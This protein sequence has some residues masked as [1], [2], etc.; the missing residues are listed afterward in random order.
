[1][2][3]AGMHKRT[4]PVY[5]NGTHSCGWRDAPCDGCESIWMTLFMARTESTM[6]RSCLRSWTVMDDAL[7]QRVPAACRRVLG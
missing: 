3:T 2:L 6:L 5:V 4:R 7:E 1:M